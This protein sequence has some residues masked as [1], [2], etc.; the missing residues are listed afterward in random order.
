VPTGNGE[1]TREREYKLDQKSKQVINLKEH[2]TN[3]WSISNNQLKE[4]PCGGVSPGKKEKSQ[5]MRLHILTKLEEKKKN[6]AMWGMDSSA[7]LPGER[8]WISLI[9]QGR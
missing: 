6:K 2:K 8:A 1:K 5:Y 3:R 4:S 7:P 9:S